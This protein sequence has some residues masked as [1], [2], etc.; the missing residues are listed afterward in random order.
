MRSLPF[1]S[2]FHLL[3]GLCKANQSRAVDRDAHS[4]CDDTTS[5]KNII[6]WVR[7][8]GGYFSSKQ[9]FRRA[10]PGDSSSFFGIFATEDIVEGELLTSV[11]WKCVISAEDE[12]D[13]E[14]ESNPYFFCASKRR[15]LSEMRM[16]DRSFYGPYITYLLNQPRGKIPSDWSNAGKHLLEDVILGYDMLSPIDSIHLLQLWKGWC[17][18][19]DDDFKDPLTQQ[20][21]IEYHTRADDA[22]LIPLY[23]LYNNFQGD[24]VNSL[25]QVT[26]GEKQDVV[27][28]RNIRKGEELGYSYSQSPHQEMFD[29]QYYST[30]E[31]LRDYGFVETLLPQRWWFGEI[32]FDVEEGNSDDDGDVKITWLSEPTPKDAAFLKDQ[33]VRL[34][35]AV[36]PY[37]EEIERK[38]TDHLEC[39]ED[40]SKICSNKLDIPPQ[41]EIVIIRQYFDALRAAILAAQESYLNGWVSSHDDYKHDDESDDDGI[42]ISFYD[43][44]EIEEGE[45]TP[46]DHESFPTYNW[47]DSNPEWETID[48]DW[49]GYQQISWAGDPNKHDICFIL[50]G[51]SAQSCSAFRAHY[52][53]IAAHF[54]T[55]YLES[56]RRV[57]VLGGGDSLMLHEILKYDTVEMVIHMELDQKVTRTSHKYFAS[58]PHFDDERVQ[59]W[60]GN[61]ATSLLM[62]PS[63]YFNTFDLVFVDLSESGFLSN[64]V[65]ENLNV[66]EVI[67]RLV[68]PYGI[69]IKNELYHETLMQIFDQTMLIYFEN[70]PMI[71]SWALSIGSNRKESLLHPN[72]TTMNKWDTISTV[73]ENFSASPENINDHFKF[74]HDYQKNDARAQGQC[75]LGEKVTSDDDKYEKETQQSL[76]G[77]LLIL[78][79]EKA[80]LLE[81]LEWPI[82]EDGILFQALRDSGVTPISSLSQLLVDGKA[83]GIVFLREG[84]VVA[85]T[86]P[87]ELYCAFDIHLWGAFDALDKVKASLAKA[88][89]SVT[90]SLSSYRIITGGMRG[91]ETEHDDQTKVGPQN[92]NATNHLHRDCGD[93][94]VSS[95]PILAEDVVTT[96]NEAVMDIMLQEVFEMIEKGDD[97]G[98]VAVICGKY[99]NPCPGKDV[100]SSTEENT[101]LVPFV[102]WDC[103]HSVDDIEGNDEEEITVE[104]M[105]VC[106]MKMLSQLRDIVS[107]QNK[108]LSAIVLDSSSSINM[109]KIAERIWSRDTIRED[110]LAKQFLF[111][112]PMNESS[113]DM[114]RRDFLELRRREMVDYGDLFRS[115]VKFKKSSP[116]SPDDSFE[117]GILSGMDSHFIPRLV[118]VTKAIERRTIGWDIE[119]QKVEGGVEEVDLDQEVT[120]YTE[121][122]F[123]RSAGESQ[124]A[125]QRPLAEQHVLQFVVNE[126]Y[127]LSM[128]PLKQAMHAALQNDNQSD[129]EIN[130]VDEV[131]HDGFVVASVSSQGT[132][133]LL[134]DGLSHID[135][136]VFSYDAELIDTFV[137]NFEAILLESFAIERFSY[138]EM[139]RGVGRVVNLMRDVND[140]RND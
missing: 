32:G 20:A 85:R 66:W 14:D 83:L 72:T 54:P 80:L 41:S 131:G 108:K 68:S 97:G 44:G 135:I 136:N 129:I 133:I 73:Y 35:V 43:L 137:D 127:V 18:V 84:V 117:V 46:E 69:L 128:E 70:V 134:S 86:W 27:A 65:T 3:A 39:E 88:V 138:D 42:P 9:E 22:V 11:P 140:G 16:G 38:A 24:R 59:W 132:V 60:Y 57:A 26:F 95:P 28:K 139:P 21:M 62:L 7:S 31:F 63:E 98:V 125:G 123:D 124:F 5:Q 33:L 10:V 37:L 34:V 119:I 71:N 118:N 126:E 100:L 116:S 13:D 1:L 107:R 120:W 55:R 111:I 64:S 93:D 56:V 81:N 77:I 45:R 109:F 96:N 110:L 51:Y 112:A 67:A 15:L 105:F 102:S 29:Q 6:D 78:E 12:E 23:D 104:A 122:D 25:V 130:T 99:D 36:E 4:S 47:E 61:A 91:T 2:S 52:H 89:G 115:E 121:D 49:S 106:E 79:A 114:W 19:E 113:T 50:D 76:A 48:S 17:D 53:D 75:D 87:N 58:Q 94:V 103:F 101:L 90:E 30:P 74:V 8:N 92:R 82:L 40:I